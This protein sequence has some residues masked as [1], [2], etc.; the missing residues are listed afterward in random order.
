VGKFSLAAPFPEL[1]YQ[2]V[3]FPEP[4]KRELIILFT[5]DLIGLLLSK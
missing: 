5:C 2:T 4:G 1:D 3:N